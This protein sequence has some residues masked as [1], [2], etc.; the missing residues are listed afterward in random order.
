MKID[1][2][3]EKFDIF[4]GSF[5]YVEDRS[6][7]NFVFITCYQMTIFELVAQMY[8][9]IV[10]GEIQAPGKIHNVLS[11]AQKM[12]AE[13]LCMIREEIITYDAGS[14]WVLNLDP[15]DYKVF[16]LI[17][18][19][20]EEFF[21]VEPEDTLSNGKVEIIQL[22]IAK[23]IVKHTSTTFKIEDISDDFLDVH[24]LKLK[25]I[26]ASDSDGSFDCDSNIQNTD[27]A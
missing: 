6:I 14:D 10:K 26:S 13:N 25:M 21:E 15:G 3:K 24:E 16:K 1:L 17:S 22:T 5:G 4:I 7:K 20:F 11:T 18:G 27:E 2:T 8:K 9:D 23:G 12:V 19:R